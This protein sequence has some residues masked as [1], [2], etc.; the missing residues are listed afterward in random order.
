MRRVAVRFA[1]I[2]LA[3]VTCA[4]GDTAS[5]EGGDEEQAPKPAST[6]TKTPEHNGVETPGPL[7]T[8]APTGDAD[9][10]AEPD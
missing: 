2:A 4:C 10:D 3:C 6:A 1:C 9:A 5:P 7:V 8:N